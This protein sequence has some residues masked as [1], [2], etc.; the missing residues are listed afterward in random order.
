MRMHDGEMYLVSVSHGGGGHGEEVSNLCLTDDLAVALNLA[1][2]A[3][4][5]N[6]DFS[7]MDD[8]IFIWAFN[9]NVLDTNR[10]PIFERHLTFKKV[11][12]KKKAWVEHWN[13]DAHKALAKKSSER[14]SS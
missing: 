11:T 6:Y 4:K 8:G 13:S 14:R 1:R 9:V 5:F 7:R 10:L 3:E 2:T 12:D